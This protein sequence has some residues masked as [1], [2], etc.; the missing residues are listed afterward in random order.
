M[1]Q[2]MIEALSRN[3]FAE[4]DGMTLED[5]IVSVEADDRLE[6]QRRR[7]V[8]SSIRS[9]CKAIGKSPCQIPAHP[10]FIRPH[11]KRFH[12]AQSGLKKNRIANIKSDLLFSLKKYKSG[13]SRTYMV[14][15]TT[16]WQLLWDMEVAP[17]SIYDRRSASRFMHLCSAQGIDPDD[18]DDTVAE[19]LLQSLL[20]E[21]LVTDPRGRWKKILYSWNK[22]VDRVPEWPQRKL[23]IPNDS[24]S[25]TIPLTQFPQSMQDEIEAAM[26]RWS[27]VDI[28]DEN[29]IDKP[30]ASATL[31]KRLVQFRELA[32]GLVLSGW[33]IEEV[34]SIACLVEISSAKTILRFF[35][36]R[37]GDK[38]TSRIHGLAIMIKT[39]AK[40]VVGVDDDHL[41]ALMDLC[42]RVDPKTNGMT[43]KNRDRLRPFDDP[44]NVRLILD[45]PIRVVEQI[46]RD[47]RGLER[48]ALFVQKALAMEILIMA[49]MRLKNISGLHIERHI[50]RTR[51]A[52]GEVHLVIPGDEVKNGE[53]LDFPLPSETA[54]LLNLYLNRFR[55]RLCSAT[56]PWLF[57][58]RSEDAPKSGH[59]LSIQ[60]KR[61]VFEHTGLE[62]NVHLYR[63]LTAKIYLDQNPGQYE[64]VR[65][66]LGHRSMETTIR[67]Y[68]GM[69]TAAASRHFDNTI[70]KLRGSISGEAA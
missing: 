32:S 19:M 51:A 62:I 43:D 18:V 30:L 67:A 56:N 54:Q 2:N 35:L 45:L 47:D 42:N 13:K 64:N 41:M 6:V 52:S 3:A 33:A 29:G 59:T 50:R 27:G 8:A 24:G 22:L 46:L 38:T 63:H 49:P 31:K 25:F 21:S 55:P 44:R 1:E 68:A 17:K 11:L 23:T 57:P 20:D 58:G 66:H 34:N 16:A 36:D 53:P 14:A 9:F 65:R 4:P 70:L 61:F 40:H 28:L 7:N 26:D 69:E 10:S 48:D 15:F 39:L 60:L 5:M 37:A 12:P